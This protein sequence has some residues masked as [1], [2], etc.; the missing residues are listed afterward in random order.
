[1]SSSSR[2]NI[3]KHMNHKSQSNLERGNSTYKMAESRLSVG[4]IRKHP[5]LLPAL[6]GDKKLRLDILSLQKP[7]KINI[8]G[9]NNP[10]K[11]KFA[12]RI[13]EFHKQ[14]YENY[15]D[16]QI[17]M[18]EINTLCKEN[19]VFS[20]KYSRSKK[21]EPKNDK[22]QDIKMAYEK[23]NYY[24]PSLENKKNLFNGN[25]L[26]LNE[27][28]LKNYILFGIGNQ[29]TNNRSLSFLYR[30]NRQLGDKSKNTLKIKNNEKNLFFDLN[31]FDDRDK[32][33]KD[34]I[35]DILKSQNYIHNIQETING[36]DDL[37]YFFYANNQEY[38]NDLKN[39]GSRGSSAKIS[40]RVNSGLTRFKD[41]ALKNN[42]RYYYNQNYSNENEYNNNDG[43]NINLLTET[44]LKKTKI[45]DENDIQNNSKLDFEDEKIKSESNINKID[46]GSYE[47]N[48]N[49][50]KI[51]NS[52]NL[53]NNIINDNKINDKYAKTIENNTDEYTR[54]ALEKL[55]NKIS[56]KDASLK[57]NNEIQKY[58]KYKNYDVSIK[59]NP[60]TVCNNFEATREKICKTDFLKQDI[61]LRK[62]CGGSL[63][64]LAKL[65]ENDLRAKNKVNNIEDKIIKLFCDVNNP[66]K[67]YE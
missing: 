59:I 37:D 64:N 39:F 25:I 3:Q 28:E 9:I 5:E 60:D 26:L 10:R 51:F 40:T 34:N 47:K 36:L 54:T 66:K 4:E 62:Q 38:L 41:V 44:P 32:I 14:F 24:V 67:K 12:N 15:K 29:N 11:I 46:E 45:N 16:H 53:N 30:I 22:F 56:E 2:V 23:K 55:Y 1:M 21:N 17:S 49:N 42:Q 20:L 65:E 48:Y 33:K 6:K 58:L 31:A 52:L 19:S 50:N 18:Q 27:D 57:Y 35:N 7:R 61:Y 13:N 8:N 63:N 43:F